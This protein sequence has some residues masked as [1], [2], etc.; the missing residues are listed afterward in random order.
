M[1]DAFLAQNSW[2]LTWRRMRELLQ[3]AVEKKARTR[4][5]PDDKGRSNLQVV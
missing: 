3:A 1:T 2:D 5:F 4:S